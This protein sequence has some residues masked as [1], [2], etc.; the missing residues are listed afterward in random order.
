MR[1]QYMA[2]LG[3][4]ALVA[5]ALAGCS[6]NSNQ[7]TDTGSANPNSGGTSS[8]VAKAPAPPPIVIPAGT[9]LTVRLETALGSKTSNAGDPFEAT[10]AEPVMSGGKV[11][12]PQGAS[13]SGVV[14]QAHAAGH[15]KGGSTLDLT[16]K[17]VTINGQP[18]AIQTSSVMEARKGKGKRSAAMIGGGAAG[19]ALLGGLIGG[20]KGAGI[21][22]LVGGGAGTAGAGLTGNRDI[23]LPV[24]TLLKFKLAADLAVKQGSGR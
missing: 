7:P 12:I 13:A 6:S 4:L 11:V 2:S 3:V 24:E 5:A 10:L 18:Y 19:G 9:A 16:L 22:A 20:G 15:F 14:T 17:S 21:G 23:S 8:S 1:K